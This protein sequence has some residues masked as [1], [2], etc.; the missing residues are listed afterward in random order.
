MLRRSPRQATEQRLWRHCGGTVEHGHT[1]EIPPNIE[2]VELVE[3]VEAYPYLMIKKIN[4]QCIIIYR[5]Y[6]IYR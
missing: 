1:K 5:V 6:V 2:I 4:E 3:L